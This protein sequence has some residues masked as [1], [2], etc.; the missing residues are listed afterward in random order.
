M[1]VA[2]ST[3]ARW[4]ATAGAASQ[5]VSVR[6]VPS[7]LLSGRLDARL[8]AFIRSA[9]PG[10][11]LTAW[12]EAGNLIG[13]PAYINPPNMRAVHRHMHRLCRGTHVSYGPILCMRPE[14]MPPW[15]V[16]GMDWYGLDIYDWPQF[17]FPGGPLDARGRLWPRLRQ[18]QAVI[19]HVSGHRNPALA[20]C[21]TNSLH[22]SDRP[23]W[24]LGVAEWMA[25]NGG[26]RMLTFWRRG[27]VGPWLPHDRAVISALRQCSRL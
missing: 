4:P 15:L 24:L 5:S 2:G 8:R 19:R 27:G 12:H 17:H 14:S 3:P 21:E 26:H 10:S 25:R 1:G 20:I 6:P 18:W 9:P 13:Y 16:P 7:S 11:F 23:K 22:P